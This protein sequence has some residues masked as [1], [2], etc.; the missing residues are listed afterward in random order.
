[1]PEMQLKMKKLYNNETNDQ[2]RDRD[3]LHVWHP[4]SPLNIDLTEL[5]LSHGEGYKVWDIYGN[6]YIDCCSLNLTCGYGEKK[7]IEAISNQL[8]T[9]HNIDISGSSHEPSGILAERIASLLPKELSKTVFVNSGSEGIEASIF[10]S[11]LYWQHIG[12]SR[13]RVVSFAKSYH[14]TTLVARNLSKLPHLSHPFEKP[15]PVTHID[16]PFS[17]RDLRQQES[18]PLLIECFEKAIKADAND[19]PMAVIV[20]PFL[21]VGGGIVLPSG[22]LKTLSMICKNVGTLL[23]VDEVFTGYGRTGKLF[24]FQHEEIVPDIMISSKGLASGYMPIT[25]VSVKDKIYNSFTQDPILQGLRYGHTTSGHATACAAAVASLDYLQ[26][27]SLSESAAVLGKKLLSKI[28]QYENYNNVVDIR[29]LGLIVVIEMIDSQ[30]ASELR[31]K[32]QLNGLLMKQ[33]NESLMIVP[34]L[35][36]DDKGIDWICDCMSN[37]FKG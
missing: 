35:T 14:G 15:F 23:I 9:L 4:W 1:M 11:A 3:R 30:T 21:N 13:S 36:I 26:S 37:S 31:A 18:L 20:E 29:G 10:I 32:A 12:E 8:N 24:A 2:I 25:A 19:L 5:M 28:L 16:L 7:L 34:P 27:N 6:E 17:P 22:F 33:N